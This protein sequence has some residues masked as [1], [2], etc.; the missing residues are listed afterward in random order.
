LQDILNT[1]RRAHLHKC[2]QIVLLSAEGK[3]SSEIAPTVGYTVR[4]VRH[5]THRFN[6]EGIDGLGDKL[7]GRSEPTWDSDYIETL[8]TIVQRS[9]LSYNIE[10]A[11]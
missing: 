8:T 10:A 4:N 2:A 1:T 6:A 5:W 11:E 3:R 9:P 7:R